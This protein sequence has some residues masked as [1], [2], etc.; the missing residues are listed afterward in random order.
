MT[1]KHAFTI[2]AASL[3][4]TSLAG[5]SS[6]TPRTIV[7]PS[8]EPELGDLDELPNEQAKAELAAA[9]AAYDAARRDGLTQLECEQLT[10]RFDEIHA[11]HGKSLALARFNVGVVWEE[12]GALDEAKAVY[13]ELAARDY[14]PALNN[15]GVLAWRAGDH[16]AAL[17]LFERAVAADEL[18][19]VAARNNL[20]AAYRDRYAE[21]L[22]LDDFTR[23]ERQLQN[24]LA[25][26]SSNEAA[27]ENLA[28]L[29]YDRGRLGDRSYLVL[30]RLVV[31][32]A[33]RVLEREHRASAD[34]WNIAG[35]LDMQDDNQNDA[36]RA[37]E[38]AVEIEPK[39]ADANRNIGFIA[40][41]FRDYAEAERAL[42]V[43]LESSEAARDIEI[44]LALGVAK[45]GLRKYDEAEAWYRK[46][47][48]LDPD[49]PRP[50]YNLGILTQDHLTG[51]ARLEA[52]DMLDLYGTSKQHF[53]EF[54]ED[55]EGD[56][57]YVA[58]VQDARERVVIIDDA[59]AAMKAMDQLQR[60]VDEAMRKAAVAEDERRD[61]LRE[62]ERQAAANGDPSVL[63][64]LEAEAAAEAAQRKTE[65]EAEKAARALEDA[66]QAA[67]NDAAADEQ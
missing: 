38:K 26:D 19:S 11:A 32:Q 2:L 51:D 14:P 37:F 35:L 29:Y 59:I 33:L 18:R 9:F 16:D 5:C 60:D 24:V 28:R 47:L 3:V 10:T 45:R 31:T 42:A 46:A 48:A 40:I 30:A 15:L 54:I 64:Q 23:A 50:W 20:A 62:L 52:T 67:A 21:A 25:L 13:E 1:T 12:C 55:A 49:D 61:H 41:R 56:D 17:R 53:G 22:A 66:A 57:R 6:T 27:Y 34:L 63:E 8:S 43:A 36:I 44:Y 7:P 58:A 39:H 65:A 4:V